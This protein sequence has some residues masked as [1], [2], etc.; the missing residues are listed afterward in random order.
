MVKPRTI[1]PAALPVHKPGKA[2]Q[3]EKMQ[4]PGI[5]PKLTAALDAFKAAGIRPTDEKI[6][7]LGQLRQK[8]DRPSDGSMTWPMGAPL[9]A[10]GVAWYQMHRV[11]EIWFDRTFRAFHGV[12][13]L[14][15]L[16]FMFAHAHSRPGDLTV[17]DLMG[18]EDAKKA[19][20]AWGDTLAIHD[21]HLAALCDRLTGL[22]GDKES[23]PDPDEKNDPEPPQQESAATFAALMCKAFPGASPDF[24]L[25]GIGAGDALAMLAG[26]GSDD[27]AESFER[28]EA[29][30]NFLK[31]VKWIWENHNG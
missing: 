6:I 23:I 14:Q 3:S 22:D 16:A 28:T 7:W 30:R 2:S 12:Q 17:N 1:S 15:V 31:A 29:I 24:W 26:V 9:M 18:A 13:R 21:S 4:A 25:S 27:F 20:T 5:H 10:A 8:C 19:V 11:A